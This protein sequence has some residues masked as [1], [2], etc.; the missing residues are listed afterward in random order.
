MT[1]CR[2]N[3]NVTMTRNNGGIVVIGTQPDTA[4]ITIQNELG[5][6]TNIKWQG[7]DIDYPAFTRLAEYTT[8]EGNTVRQTYDLR[9]NVIEN[10]KISKPISGLTDIVS[11]ASFPANCSNPVTCNKPTSITDAKGAVTTYTYDATHGGV[12]TE[13]SP[14]VGG[15]GPQ[16]RHEYAQRY[17]WIKDAAGT[18]YVQAATPIWVKTKERFCKAGA[19][20][21]ASCAGGAADEVVTEFDY[22][23]NAGPN[24]L[25]LRGMAVTATNSA[26]TAETQR[27]CYGYDENGRKVSETS[28][29]ANLAVCP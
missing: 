12:L 29:L 8:P 6:I 13:T 28:P 24:N 14:S 10:R 2:G 21:G 3:G 16:K 27:T 1:A 11:A 26:G 22:G 18:G 15:V 9:G 25:W 19:A 7:P 4:P 17:A 20:S 23:P 5:N